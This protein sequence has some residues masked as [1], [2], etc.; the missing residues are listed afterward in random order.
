MKPTDELKQEHE[1]I[2][3]MLKI[4]EITSQMLDAGQKVD[5]TDLEETLEFI[6]VFADKC[7]H[8]KEED[9]LFPDLQK[10]GVPKE[11]G[12]IGVMLMEHASCR[13]YVRGMAEGIEKYKIGDIDAY[14]QITANARNYIKLLSEH[15]YKENNILYP[16]ADARLSEND[17]ETLHDGFSRVE[18]EVVGKGKHEEFHRLLDKLQKIYLK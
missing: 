16:M 17:Q 2:K 10:V 14:K 4:L 9:L 3:L 13:N 1:A 15:I 8:H 6:R 11:Q 12:P 5:T 7:H 18:E